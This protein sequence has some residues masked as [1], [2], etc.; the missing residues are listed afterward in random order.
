[1]SKLS[2]FADDSKLGK[3]VS[4]LEDVESL[5][6]VLDKLYSWSETWQMQLNV[7]KCSVIHLGHNNRQY[8]YKL[9]DKQLRSSQ[10]ERDLGIIIDSSMKFS[11]HCG[12]IVK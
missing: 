2:K 10:S 7:D 8:N 4:S 12:H 11:E 9:G 5:Q 3:T 6:E 1:M